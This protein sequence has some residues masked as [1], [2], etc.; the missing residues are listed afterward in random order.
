MPDLTRREWLAAV[1]ASTAGA[2]AMGLPA[3]ALAA[4]AGVDDAGRYVLPPLPYATDA[5]E[6]HLDAQTLTIHHD[7]HHAGYVNGLN[8]TLTKLDAA[9][10]AGDLGHIQAL[11]RALAFHGCGHLLH[12]LYWSSMAPESKAPSG[13]L[14]KAIEASFGTVEAMSNQLGAAS[15]TAAGSG[16]GLLVWEPL[17]RRLMVV[18]VEKHENQHL[19]GAVPLLVIDVWEHAYYLKYQNRRADY[20]AAVMKIINWEEVA[21]RLDQARQATM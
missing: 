2:A 20:V 11:S 1:G 19:V 6:P 10:K 4:P 3:L 5:L 17:G 21:R 12:T 13:E 18:Q 9:R 16:W 14:R 7:K 8:G 15:R